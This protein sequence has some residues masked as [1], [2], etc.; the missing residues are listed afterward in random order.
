LDHK[1][2]NSNGIRGIKVEV[3][4]LELKGQILYSADLRI[5]DLL[6]NSHVALHFRMTGKPKYEVSAI[7]I[8]TKTRRLLLKLIS[9]VEALER[10]IV[11]DLKP[12]MFEFTRV[13]LIN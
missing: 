9:N 10:W 13:A 12:G 2:S 5:K 4:D 11:P 7:S 6:Y 3:G 1:S 8:E